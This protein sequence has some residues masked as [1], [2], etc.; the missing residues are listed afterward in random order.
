MNG[1][2]KV[3]NLFGIPFYVNPSWFLVLILITFSYGQE[4]ASLPQL[5]GIAALFLGFLTAI[6]LFA[7]VL[8][9]ELGHSFVAKAQGIEVKS[10]T[11]FLFGGLASLDKESKTPL[12]AFFVAIA[13]PVVSLCLFAILTLATLKITLSLPLFRIIYLL[14]SIN[15]VLA[16]FNL[17]PGLPLDGGNILKAIVWQVTGNPNK[18]IIFAS[19]VG[20]GFGWLAVTVG[21]MGI[22]RVLPFGSFWT[23]LMGW[24]LLQNAGM[25]AQSAEI[26][27]TLDRY[28]TEEAIIADSPI[29]SKDLSLREF[30]NDHIIGKEKWQKFLAVDAEGKLV[31]EIATEDL[32]NVATSQWTTTFVWELMTEI[33]VKTVNINESLLEA[34]KLMEEET[35]QQLVV[36]NEDDRVLGVIDR[37][38]IINLL[39]QKK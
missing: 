7:S 26:Q 11:L 9:H 17:I 36:V 16:L 5:N 39:Q 10:I 23:L 34:A 18:G 12:Q 24:F 15:L 31:G 21:I 37:L 19:R 25:S 6:L 29:V 3:G 20:Q 8:A 14:A 32:K 33:A 30:A 4:L 28:R 1:N 2:I 13:G 27:E 35:L 38:S 22:L